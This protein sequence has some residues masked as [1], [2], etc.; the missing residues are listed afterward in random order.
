MEILEQLITSF[1]AT[2]GFG[3]LFNAPRNMLGK[4]G[5]VGMA[6]WLV[7]F[8]I[9]KYISDS[10]SATLAAAFVVAVISHMLAKKNRT[11]V[12][13]FSVSGIIPLV[14]GGISYDAMR[15]FVEIDYSTALSLA[16]KAFLLSGAI[17]MGLVFSEVLNHIWRHITSPDK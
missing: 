3:I 12:I 13:I 16:G 7:Y 8:L 9:E 5:I 10:V 15:H 14:P 2:A 17:A 11:P 1:L 4:C 6:G